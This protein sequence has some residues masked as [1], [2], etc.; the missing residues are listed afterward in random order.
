VKSR[1]AGVPEGTFDAITAYIHSRLGGI[2]RTESGGGG[3]V[4]PALE[5]AEKAG[6]SES[7]AEHVDLLSAR[8]KFGVVNPASKLSSITAAMSRVGAAGRL[9]AGVAAR[10]RG[11]AA[12]D[13]R[14]V[15][16]RPARSQRRARHRRRGGRQQHRA[17]TGLHRG[18]V[19]HAGMVAAALT[20][21]LTL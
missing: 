20:I 1:L 18:G 5:L 2:R 16:V 14:P 7:I 17:G 21:S 4:V 15:P 3:G 12:V 8:V 13:G 19:Q 9:R 10:P 6:L 11:A